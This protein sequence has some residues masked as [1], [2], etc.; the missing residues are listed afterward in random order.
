[1]TVKRQAAA[2]AGSVIL[3]RTLA[4]ELVRVTERAA[5]ATARFRGRGDE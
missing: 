1:M 2:P 5:I 3:D 4:L